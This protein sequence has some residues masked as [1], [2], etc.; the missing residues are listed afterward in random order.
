MPF[1]APRLRVL[2]LALIAGGALVVHNSRYAAEHGTAWR[3]ALAEQGH[4]YLTLLLPV[5]GLALVAGVA[6]W[7][8]T[9]R[10]ARS[11]RR[12]GAPS[13]PSFRATWLVSTLALVAIYCGQEALEGV[14]AHGHADGIG[15]V[16]GAGGW[17][18]LLLAAGVGALIALL[19]TAAH[20][21]VVLVG[22]GLG[23]DVLMPGS[24]GQLTA[25]PAI[26]PR[27]ILARHAGGRGPPRT[28]L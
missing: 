9:V 28:S 25:V 10:R 1:L 5:A 3:E 7:A 20:A 23:F 26:A 24:L 11:G 21:C 18:A 13:R 19:L 2:H 22:D 4:A 14:L 12:A 8:G 17:S 15:G 16:F 6:M 27:G